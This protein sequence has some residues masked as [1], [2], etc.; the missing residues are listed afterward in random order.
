M[1][2]TPSAEGSLE[3]SFA[4]LQ[5]ATDEL[6]E[7]LDTGRKTTIKLRKGVTLGDMT[8]ARKAI[9][10]LS[11]L[12]SELDRAHKKVLEA[13]PNDRELRAA[14]SGPLLTEIQRI[15][16]S[17]GL[18]IS[19]LDG[20]LVAFPVIVESNP[21][22]LT[23]KIGRTTSKS[24]RP[25]AVVAQIRAAMK[26]ARSKPERFIELLHGAAQWV[27]A[28]SAKSSGVRLDDVYKVITLHPDTKKNYSP[29]DFAVD[30]YTLDTSDV[31]ATKKGTRIFFL[32]AT[33][34]KGSSGTFSIVGP[35]SAPRH[36]VGIRFEE[37]HR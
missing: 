34:A 23:V 26:K 24:L 22:N 16:R 3:Y 12:V 8:V 19:A 6:L 27:N 5:S 17:E 29:I 37:E 21:E 11:S 35:D 18:T 1:T 36:Y 2:T 31:S 30:L 20:R 10:D 13:A 28:D 7:R 25:S 32:G 15:G 14:L 33:G 9:D 4:V